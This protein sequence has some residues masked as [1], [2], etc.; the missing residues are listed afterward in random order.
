MRVNAALPGPICA[1][2]IAEPMLPEAL[3]R[4]GD[5]TMPGRPSQPAELAPSCV[6]FASQGGSYPTGSPPEL[7][8]GTLK[9]A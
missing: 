1:P 8:G 2:L 3:D 4:L 9:I 6:Y 5:Q 7:A